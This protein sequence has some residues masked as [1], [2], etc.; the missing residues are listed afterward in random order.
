LG[1]EE[2][3]LKNHGATLPVPNFA[4]LPTYGGAGG[5]GDDASSVGGD[6]AFSGSQF[7]GSA[8]RYAALGGTNDRGP[9]LGYFVGPYFADDSKRDKK[10]N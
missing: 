10:F 4:P 2:S 7:G 9:S 3:S 1:L 8:N 5:G 6:S